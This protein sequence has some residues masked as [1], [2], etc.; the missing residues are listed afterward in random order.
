LRL[1]RFSATRMAADY[2]RAY[3]RLGRTASEDSL[4]T[5][6]KGSLPNSPPSEL[7]TLRLHDVSAPSRAISWPTPSLP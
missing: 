1:E 2:E 6:L 3:R 4:A 5:S 7:A